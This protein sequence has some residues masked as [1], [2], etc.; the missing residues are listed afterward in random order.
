MPSD[1]HPLKYPVE[2]PRPD[3]PYSSPK[4]N[5]QVFSATTGKVL[6]Y[7]QLFPSLLL[8]SLSRAS[9]LSVGS[10]LH[11]PT[12]SPYLH[13]CIPPPHPGI[14]LHTL[15]R[16]IFLKNHARDFRNTITA[17][18]VHLDEGNKENVQIRL[19]VRAT[20]FSQGEQRWLLG[21]GDVCAEL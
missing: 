1:T 6:L 9:L 10:M 21:R 17:D 20:Y 5:N 8:H 4:H 15:G 12:L 2:T 13:F 11:I 19:D 3:A 14:F 7:I 18:W 16:A